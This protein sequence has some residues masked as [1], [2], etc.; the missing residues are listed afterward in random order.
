MEPASTPQS[1]YATR[2][3]VRQGEA[4]RHYRRYWLFARIRSAIVG[5]VILLALLGEKERLLTKGGLLALPALL[6]EVAMRIRDRAGRARLRA[7][8]AARFY[9]QRLACVEDRWTGKGRA[10][11]RFRDENHP[12][13]NDLDLFG[14]G[15][16]F[17]LLCTAQT[18]L[19]EEMLAGW[20]LHPSGV[21]EIRAR[22]GARGRCAELRSRLDLREDLMILGSDVPGRGPG[23]PLRLGSVRS[24]P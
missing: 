6:L 16:L 8:L 24:H 22:Q 11:L 15:C 13:A 18:S 10:G 21:E 20:L 3:R 14:P 1:E 2:L 4:H 9:E 23:F 17:E 5:V 19:G 7:A 12:F